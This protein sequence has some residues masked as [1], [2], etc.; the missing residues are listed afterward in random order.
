MF[1]RII[2]LILACVLAFSAAAAE[3]PAGNAEKRILVIETTDI[4]GYIVD[5]SAGR[6]D[7]FQYRLARIAQ[8]IN[9]ARASGEYDDVLL[10]DGGD[11]YQGTPRP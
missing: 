5:A 10:L 7:R 6:E 4:H 8:L 9:E 11:L 3:G 2:G 1:R